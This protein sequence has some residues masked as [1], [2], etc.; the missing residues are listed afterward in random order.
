[1]KLLNM[2]LFFALILALCSTSV[3]AQHSTA[4]TAAV[5]SPEIVLKEFYKW[6]IYSI[7]HYKK[8]TA[9]F[10]GGMA[11]LKKYVTLRFIRATERNEK[12]PEGE[13]WDADYF[14][15]NQD[16]SGFSEKNITVS[17][18]VIK[19]A[20]ATA[21]VTF[22]QADMVMVSLI[23]EGGV[24][25]IDKVKNKSGDGVVKIER[26]SRAPR[27]PPPASAV[28]KALRQSLKDWHCQHN[29]GIEDE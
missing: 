1:M 21:I 28:R 5:R 29:Q 14:L 11:T 16:T 2:A 26:I 6:Y 25:K 27:T 23:Q 22:D 18:V 24:W 20:T 4:S 19:G 9:P 3:G 12:L 17:K 10:E 7:N 8:A 13:G 15:L